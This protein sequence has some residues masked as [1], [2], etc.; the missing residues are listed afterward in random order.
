MSI[1]VYTGEWARRW[2]NAASVE[3]SLDNAPLT[4]M[5]AACR[6]GIPKDEIGLFEIGGSMVPSAHV[7]RDG[8][9][10]RVYPQIIGG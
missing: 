5:E 1:Q 6:C 10:L 9:T 8:E 4:A 3:I 7:L 2:M